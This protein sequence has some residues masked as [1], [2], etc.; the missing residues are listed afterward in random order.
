MSFCTEEEHEEFMRS[1]PR[2]EQIIQRSGI[3]LLK[4]WLSVSDEEQERRFHARLNDP[5]KRWKLSPID[6]EAR[7]R[8]VDY[9]EAKDEMFAYTDTKES[10]WFVVEGD[11]KRSARLNL[12]AHL[13]DQIPYRP[14]DHET[15]DLP[16][17]QE[18]AYVRPAR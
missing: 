12:I 17:R 10:P 1:C 9:A 2:F 14:V 8:W 4:Y 18:R 6:L 13:L 15:I 3:V 11:D 16:P 7:A 5:A